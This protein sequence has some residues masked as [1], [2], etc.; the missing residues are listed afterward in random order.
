MANQYT[1]E[2][3]SKCDVKAKTMPH[4]TLLAKDNFTP[5]LISEWIDMA[6][7]RGTP[8]PKINEA[9][10]LLAHIE[11]WRRANPLE[12]KTPD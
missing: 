2:K 7:E 9:R 4:F 12:C 6:I 3:M 11:E 10:R 8:Q 1:F 5:I